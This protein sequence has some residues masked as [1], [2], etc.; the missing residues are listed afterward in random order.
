MIEPLPKLR[1]IWPS[2]KV[3]GVIPLTSTGLSCGGMRGFHVGWHSNEQLRSK[4]VPQVADVSQAW[5]IRNLKRQDTGQIIQC[6]DEAP[7]RL[8]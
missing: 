3:Q 8:I 5:K 1:S 4:Q 6:P 7:T 2:T